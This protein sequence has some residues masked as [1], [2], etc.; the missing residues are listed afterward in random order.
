MLPTVFW[1]NGE[2]L[3]RVDYDVATCVYVGGMSLIP[4]MTTYSLTLADF[5]LFFLWPRIEHRLQYY[6][7]SVFAV[8]TRHSTFIENGPH[9]PY[10]LR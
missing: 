5:F 8:V 2:C 6:L 4:M 9:G 3:Q 10:F 1:L 7:V